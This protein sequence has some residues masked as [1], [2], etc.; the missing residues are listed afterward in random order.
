M[1]SGAEVG[2]FFFLCLSFTLVL[3]II[4]RGRSK[5]FNDIDRTLLATKDPFWSNIHGL[6]VFILLT[7]ICA[8]FLLV[9]VESQAI[10][11]MFNSTGNGEGNICG[12]D[13]FQSMLMGDELVDIDFAVFYLGSALIPLTWTSWAFLQEIKNSKKLKDARIDLLLG[14]INQDSNSG[15]SNSLS[16]NSSIQ[17]TSEE[18]A[19][20]EQVLAAMDLE[21]KKAI[22]AANELKIELDETK[23]KVVV[24][25]EEVQEKDEEISQIKDSKSRFDDM[26]NE[27][28]LSDG[29]NG[30]KNLSLTDS[31][32]VGDSIMG[33]V[34]IDKQINN[35]AEAIAKAVIDAYRK[36]ISD[37]S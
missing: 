3:F 6:T 9:L 33:G 31:V 13:Y 17:Q 23:E 26:I 28:S 35:D 29:E 30:G 25:E 5:Y 34:K 2:L 20:F 37:S 1:Q 14:R 19:T 7:I 10:T 18:P 21:L 12:P 32:M 27:I 8:D 11:C 36:G 24:L 15:I 16:T 4:T 22:Q